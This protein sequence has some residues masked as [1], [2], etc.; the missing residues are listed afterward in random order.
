[1]FH[2]LYIRLWQCFFLERNTMYSAV[3][4]FVFPTSTSK[5]T[6]QSV[7]VHYLE[8]NSP[9]SIFTVLFSSLSTRPTIRV[10]IILFTCS[11]ALDQWRHQNF[12]CSRLERIRRFQAELQVQLLSDPNEA[13]SDRWTV[14]MNNDLSLIP[15][16]KSD[17]SWYLSSS[18]NVRIYFFW[19]FYSDST[20]PSL[21]CYSSWA[22]QDGH[23]LCLFIYV[24]LLLFFAPKDKYD[25]VTGWNP[26]VFIAHFLFVNFLPLLP[27]SQTVKVV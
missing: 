10:V 15:A 11:A 25:I 24:L 9:N 1:M 16:F 27:D 18:R 20:T 22:K 19:R 14:I 6:L 5:C 23:P 3:A 8:I 26:Q 7:P 17:C 4:Y 13:P 21:H 2:G 12:T